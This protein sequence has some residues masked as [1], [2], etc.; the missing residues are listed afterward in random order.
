MYIQHRILRPQRAIA[1]GR[2]RGPTDVQPRAA[3]IVGEEPRP[4]LSEHLDDAEFQRPG[5]ISDEL[6][7]AVDPPREE[8]A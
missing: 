7:E 5:M 6:T 1:I 3:F 8:G 2:E 4:A